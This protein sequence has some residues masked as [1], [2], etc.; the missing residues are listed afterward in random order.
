MLPKLTQTNFEVPYSEANLEKVLTNL[1]YRMYVFGF[2][3][4]SQVKISLFLEMILGVKDW[5]GQNMN[6]GEKEQSMRGVGFSKI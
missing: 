3:P 4:F 1:W 2:K 5:G 6:E